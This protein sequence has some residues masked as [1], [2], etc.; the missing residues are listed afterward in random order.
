MDIPFFSLSVGESDKE[1]PNIQSFVTANNIKN[2]H[3]LN[4]SASDFSSMFLSLQTAF[5]SP[6]SDSSIALVGL[7]SQYAR[8][9][10]KGVLSGDGADELLTVILDINVLTYRG[11]L[12]KLTPFY[13]LNIFEY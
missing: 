3:K 9:F 8:S 2:H 11:G 7:I 12:S 6:S 13:L 1:M 5:D 4:V 10:V